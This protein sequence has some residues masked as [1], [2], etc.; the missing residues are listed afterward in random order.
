MLRAAL[1]GMVMLAAGGLLATALL[2]ASEP[3]PRAW[4]ESPDGGAWTV[5]EPP[6][7]W[8]VPARES[9][10]ML[11]RVTVT[12]ARRSLADLAACESQT[13]RVAAA[14]RK[15]R[16]RACATRPL[17]RVDGFGTANGRMLS[18]LASTAGPSQQCRGRLLSLS[19]LTSALGFSARATL[20]GWEATGDEL[21]ASS[22]AI[23]AAAREAM[24]LA[25][26][27]G[28]GAT[29]RPLPPAPKPGPPTA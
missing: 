21:I 16:F 6:A 26:A 28:W 24:K 12:E 5:E 4:P 15:K 1:L 18:N 14:A 3:A 9:L 7:R 2:R 23:R 27:P 11:R 17:A 20:R 25:R 13:A 22:R 8:D 19:G 29:C 10:A